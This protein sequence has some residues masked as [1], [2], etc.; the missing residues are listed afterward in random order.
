MTFVIANAELLLDQVHH[1]RAGPQACLVARRFRCLLEQLLQ[2]LE[3]V[4]TQQRLASRSPGF[5]QALLALVAILL[6]PACHRLADH[7]QPSRNLGLLQPFFFQQPDR[8]ETTLFQRLE[9]ASHS[10]RISH[11]R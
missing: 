5:L 1:P 2:P 9:I 3:I 6:D 7:L 8:L 10:G 11:A 4:R